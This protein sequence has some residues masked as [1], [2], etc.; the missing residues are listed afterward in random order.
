MGGDLLPPWRSLGTPSTSPL[1]TGVPPCPSSPWVWV[2]GVLHP[3]ESSACRFNSKSTTHPPQ[4][5]GLR[6][7]SLRPHHLQWLL[8][9]PLT[10]GTACLASCTPGASA[11]PTARAPGS[12]PPC[13]PGI[14]I[15]V[16]CDKWC[17][18][19]PAERSR[20]FPGAVGKQGCSQSLSS[21]REPPPCPEL[22][23]LGAITTLPVPWPCL[24]TPDP[25]EPQGPPL[26]TV[27]TPPSK[28]L[29]ATPGPPHGSPAHRGPKAPGLAFTFAVSDRGQM[30]LSLQ[31]TTEVPGAVRDSP[32]WGSTW[33]LVKEP[34]GVAGRSILASLLSP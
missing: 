29:P 28:E 8:G 21:P 1:P 24:Q 13:H 23:V 22:R 11:L 12:E 9:D 5:V 19:P 16:A 17:F 27:L 14:A 18:R 34:A 30:Q 3:V 15:P 33:I 26:V 32:L 25:L 2:L 10:L 6:L 4:K 7:L 20:L 31:A